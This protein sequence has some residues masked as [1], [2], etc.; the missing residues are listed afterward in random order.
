ML[1]ASKVVVRAPAS[2]T[3]PILG[4]PVSQ[5]ALPTDTFAAQEAYQPSRAGRTRF[6][7]V[8]LCMDGRVWTAL[9]KAMPISD[10]T[11]FT[12]RQAPLTLGDIVA[13]TDAIPPEFYLD[14]GQMQ[15]WNYVKGRKSLARVKANGHAYTYSEGAVPFPDPLDKPSRTII[16]SEGGAGV[17]RTRHVVATPDGRLRRLTPE[18]LEQ[19]NGFPRGFTALPDLS[20]SQRA[21]LMGNALVTGLVARIGVALAGGAAAHV[22]RQSVL[23][24]KPRLPE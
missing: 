24:S 2:T 19:L 18:E 6:G 11:V 9:A 23:Q 7:S 12:G 5:L 3:T 4:G 13:A 20:A 15:K 17:S 14:E 16:T 1:P 21:F 10:F 8:G 22:D